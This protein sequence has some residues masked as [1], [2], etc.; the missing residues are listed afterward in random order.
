MA[1]WLNNLTG[2]LDTTNSVIGTMQDVIDTVANFG[3]EPAVATPT[4]A[5]PVAAPVASAS[6]SGMDGMLVV[7]VAVILAV[8]LLR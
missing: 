4:V 3:H 7:V 2:S 6:G 1:K 5:A 8:V